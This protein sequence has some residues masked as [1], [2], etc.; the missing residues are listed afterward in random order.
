MIVLHVL[1]GIPYQ[2]GEDAEVK[3]R[4]LL[5]VNMKVE[6][7]QNIPYGEPYSKSGPVMPGRAAGNNTTI[8]PR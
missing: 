1:D 5:S 3:V 2:E 8:E 4:Q 7:A 6:N